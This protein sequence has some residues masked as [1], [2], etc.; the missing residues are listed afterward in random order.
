M[1]WSLLEKIK[2]LFPTLIDPHNSI[3]FLPWTW[4]GPNQWV[5]CLII[6]LIGSYRVA[7]GSML[8]RYDRRL[9]PSKPLSLSWT[10]LICQVDLGFK[11]LSSPFHHYHCH[12]HPSTTTAVTI[13]IPPLSPLFYP[14]HH[15][16]NTTTIVIIVIIVTLISLLLSPLLFHNKVR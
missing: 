12:D 1:T 6:N 16:T 5:I 2:I 4:P 3:C 7:R 8:S 9:D 11:T 13:T 15:S 10:S 14:H